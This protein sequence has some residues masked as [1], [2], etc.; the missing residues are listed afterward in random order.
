MSSHTSGLQAIELPGSAS[1]AETLLRVRDAITAARP[2][3]YFSALDGSRLVQRQEDSI[4]YPSIPEVSAVLQHHITFTQTN[5]KGEARQ[6]PLPPLVA[7][8][9]VHCPQPGLW[10]PLAG[11]VHHPVLAAD[12][13]LVCRPGYDEGT[14]LWL[15]WAGP[16]PDPDSVT[17]EEVAEVWWR[18]TDFP[19][20]SLSDLTHAMGLFLNPFVRPSVEGPTP[21]H[22]IESVGS[23]EAGTPGAGVGKTYLAEL[24]GLVALGRAPDVRGLDGWR[25][26]ARRQLTAFLL[27]VP[28]YLF[29]DNLPTDT[30]LNEADL[31]RALTVTGL[32]GLRPTGAGAERRVPVRCTWVATANG[33]D[34][35]SEQARRT[36]PIRLKGTRLHAYRTPDLSRWVKNNRTL[37]VSAFLWMI[38]EWV[39]AGRPKP[40]RTLP[41]Y[42]R[43]SDVVGG[44][45]AHYGRSVGGAAW[46]A[47][48]HRP[49]PR[50]ERDWQTLYE[51]WPADR[52]G[53][54]R[55][56]ALA[57][58]AVVGLVEALDL[59]GIRRLLPRSDKPQSLATKMGGMLQRRKN[60]VTGDWCLRARNA[61]NGVV[62]W[63]E[64]IGGPPEP[65]RGPCGTEFPEVPQENPLSLLWDAEPAEPADPLAPDPSRARAPAHDGG[66]W[67]GPAGPAGSATTEGDSTFSIGAEAEPAS[68]GPAHHP[69]IGPGDWLS[70][71]DGMAARGVRID[72]HL[73]QEAV[74]ALREEWW[75][76][77]EGSDDLLADLAQKRR[78]ALAVYADSVLASAWA[79]PAQRVRASWD[80][81][82]AWTGRITATDPPLQ[83]ITKRGG[84]RAAVVPA[85]GCKFVVADFSQSQLRIVAGLSGDEG[86]RRALQPGRD[87]HREIGELA[88]PGHPEGRALGKLLNF[89]I[90]YLAGVDGLVQS[91][92]EA[93]IPLERGDVAQIR[94]RVRGGYPRLAAW[95]REQEGC[96]EFL[97]PLGRRVLVPSSSRD[98]RTG[99][100]RLPAVL[101]GIAQAAEADALRLVLTESPRAMAGLDAKIVLTI[102]DE[103][104]WE[105][106]EEHAAEA[107]RR[108][109]E[110][111]LRAL[112]WVCAP[113]EPAVTVE[114]RGSWAKTS[115]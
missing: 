112:G 62:Y 30:L 41:S 12:W 60:V 2:W 91:A 20:E 58:G 49:R 111:M 19:F 107:A 88:A 73:W 57:A 103:V 77:A 63:P 95:Q 61:R 48:V 7:S 16:A 38:R 51:N 50:T 69:A 96:G 71:I 40:P 56:A 45:V 98:Q 4:I 90:L 39:D 83:G 52:E 28:E 21:M 18:L 104:I 81:D 97:S 24:V 72:P 64:R 82:G 15:N 80:A 87:P 79:D 115:P 101:A 3:I 75:Y 14:K 105:V 32:L 22:M 89:A 67:E 44:I 99:E 92:R 36:I 66:E 70:E 5:K 65:T 23:G 78:D 54:G 59:S 1:V 34:F 35:D 93:G 86:L 43:W 46:L 29:L 85:P 6:V 31:H 113:C 102:H 94:G 11:V 84:L 27:A 53:A 33:P 55:P 106:H 68:A 42:T 25:S 10:W 74:C 114:V 17:A 110:L 76:E 100:P 13:R 109:R 108:A 37:I 26:E 9:L 8:N 47:P